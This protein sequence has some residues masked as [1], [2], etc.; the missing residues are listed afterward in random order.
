MSYEG[1]EIKDLFEEVYLGE[2]G[3][4]VTVYH[5]WNSPGMTSFETRAWKDKAKGITVFE[6]KLGTEVYVGNVIQIADSR[7][8]WRVEDVEDEIQLGSRIKHIARVT[9]INQQGNP[10]QLN[11]EGK[12]VH[13][14]TNIQ[15]HN[16][17]G[18]QQGGQGNVQNI[19]LTHTNNPDF[20]RALASLV[21]IIRSSN[22]P[23]DDKEE[24]QGE[25]ASINKLALKE[26]NPNTLER[27]KLK[28]DYLKTSL[29][30]ADLAVKAAPYLPA[31]Y[32]FF[33]SLPQ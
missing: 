16:Y 23:A 13:Y 33:Q 15:G 26:Q 11:S 25:V 24:L 28:L 21:E 8:F 32:Q 29:T 18:I 4:E 3:I 2:M 7:D 6:F 10:I 20:D 14:T 9:K 19:T 5:D 22:L 30:A 27:A 17:G 1:D 31:L 12:A